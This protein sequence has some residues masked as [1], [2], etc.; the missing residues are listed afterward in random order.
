MLKNHAQWIILL[1]SHGYDDP[2]TTLSLRVETFTRIYPKLRKRLF[3]DLQM[4]GCKRYHNASILYLVC[5]G[6][7]FLLSAEQRTE[8]HSNV[9]I[10]DSFCYSWCCFLRCLRHFIR[11]RVTQGVFP[12]LLQ[13]LR[14][15]CGVLVLACE[16]HENEE[17]GGS[18]E[19]SW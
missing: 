18:Q 6:V 7:H 8:S 5:S 14:D 19:G 11:L 17:G 9:H 15:V 4:P 13:P 16:R 3:T 1:D 2:I 12:F 10:A